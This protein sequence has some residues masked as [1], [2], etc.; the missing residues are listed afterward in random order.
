MEMLEEVLD[1]EKTYQGGGGGGAG[2][3]GETAPSGGVGGDGGVGR[4]LP[5]TFRD[6]RQMHHQIHQTH[7]HIKEVVV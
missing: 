2:G 5:T 1:C 3:A 6:S 7:N 4:Q